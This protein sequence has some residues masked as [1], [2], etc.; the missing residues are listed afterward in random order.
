[1]AHKSAVSMCLSRARLAIVFFL[2]HPQNTAIAMLQR[3]G[4][5]IDEQYGIRKATNSANDFNCDIAHYATYYSVIAKRILL[6]LW[7]L[8]P[9]FDVVVYVNQTA[10]VAGSMIRVR[11]MGRSE[12]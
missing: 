6:S 12:G 7:Y 9:K 4:S 1:M 10:L 3:L 11:I 2:S 5:S 8:I